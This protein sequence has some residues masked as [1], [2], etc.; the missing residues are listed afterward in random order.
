M[1]RGHKPDRATNRTGEPHFEQFLFWEMVTS[2]S[3]IY[4][5]LP[6]KAVAVTFL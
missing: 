6:K 5:T 4:L 2:L 1:Q 3:E